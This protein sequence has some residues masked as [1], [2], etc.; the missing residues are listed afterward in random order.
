MKKVALLTAV[1]FSG[2]SAVAFAAHPKLITQHGK[3]SAYELEEGKDKVCY[4]VS[5]P[6]KEEGKYSK[7]GKVY[8]MVTH[9]PAEKSY[10]VVSFHAGYSFT[11]G[12]TAK[13]TVGKKDFKLFTEN[14]T[15]WA[16]NDMDGAIVEEI[17]RGSKLIINGK[18]ARKTATKDT[19]SL[20][21]SSVVLKAMD[22]ACGVN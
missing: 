17:R 2:L 13:V 14:E 3:W 4:M 18:S 10:N 12:D 5:Q 20:T 9:R 15:A 19:Y 11:P 6:I 16:E 1:L 8:A 7:R 21:G 22:K